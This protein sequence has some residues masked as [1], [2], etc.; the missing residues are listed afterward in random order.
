MRDVIECANVW[1]LRS[2]VKDDNQLVMHVMD[3]KS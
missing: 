3:R 1:G 2:V